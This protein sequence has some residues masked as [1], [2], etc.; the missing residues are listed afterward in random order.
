ML[1]L[2]IG[3]KN[4][5]SWAMRVGVLMAQARIPHEQVLVRFDSFDA[6]SAFKQRLKAVSPTGKVPLLVDGH[7]K[8]WDTLAICEY[9][10]EQFPDQHLWPRDKAARAVARS[11]VAEL[12]S[13][14]GAL[15]QHC[16]MNIEAQL[17]EVGAIIWRDQPGVRADVQRACALFTELL[18]RHGGPLLFGEFCIA[19]AYYAPMCTR[20]MTYGIPLPETVAAYAR[21][22]LQL[23]GVKAWCDAA[24]AEHDF[25]AFEEPYRLRRTGE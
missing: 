10:A 19:D 11:I 12:H 18:A 25:V 8:V 20:F 1:Q 23:P 7:L 3:N 9:L 21:R 2:Y 17:P 6:D 22:V 5:S 24:R 14:F 13:G 4:Y 16:S 15:R